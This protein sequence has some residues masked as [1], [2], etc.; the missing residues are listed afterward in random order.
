MNPVAETTPISI[1]LIVKN[2]ATALRACLVSLRSFIRPCDEI[3][4][5]DTGSDDETPGV[6]VDDKTLHCEKNVLIRTDLNRSDMLAL[7]EKYLPNFHH[8][9]SEDPQFRGGFLRSF[10]EARQIVTDAAKHDVIFWLDSDDI[11]LNG[12]ALRARTDL[13]F[14]EPA[15]KILFLPYQY[16]FDVDGSC[17]TL[18][19]RERLLRKSRYHW[20][21]A[22]HETIVPNIPTDLQ[23]HRLDE[24]DIT[25]KHA[26]A[27]HHIFSDIRN[28]AILRESYDKEKSDGWP[29][30]RT[31]FYLGNACRGMGMWSEAIKWYSHAILRSG[32]RDDRLSCGLNIAYGYLSFLRPWKALDW[33]L[34]C[35]KIWTDEPRAYYG[36]AKCYFDLHKW[37]ECLIWTQIG[38][39]MGVPMHMTAVDPLSFTFYPR[40]FE[41][42]SLKS[43][44]NLEAAIRV[45]SE[46][47]AA[48]PGLEAAKLLLQDLQQ[49]K[50]NQII[51]DSLLTALGCA[52]SADAG[53]EIIARLKPEVRQG[54]IELHVESHATKPEKSVTFFCGSTFEPW[55]GSSLLN[56]V[57]GSEKMVIQ[58]GERLARRGWTVDVYGKPKTEHRYKVM[59]GVAYRP[60]ESFDPKHPRDVLVLW[61]APAL[62]NTPFKAR[63][64]LVDM[65]DVTFSDAFTP[66][67]LS[68]VS[69]VIFKSKFHRELAP[70]IPD[71]KAAV[72][73]N[74]IDLEVLDRVLREPI[75]RNYH[76]VVW[77]SSG[78]RGLRGALVTW[79]HC[80][81]E[82]P[83]TDFNVFYGFTPLYPQKATETPYQIF[84][85]CACERHMFDYAEECCELQARLG[86]ITPGRVSTDDLY[87]HLRSA[88]VWLYPTKFPEISCISAMDAQ[89]CG[90][91]PLCSDTAALKETVTWGAF[92]EHNEAEKTAAAIRGLMLKGKDYDQYR[93]DMMADARKRFDLETLVDEWEKLIA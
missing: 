48:R 6:L 66:D 81:N 7:V 88:G 15:N 64:I 75:D 17:N 21:G 3:I 9:C 19:W 65:H 63:K 31:E 41:A 62:L 74:A 72:L 83:A 58:I 79:A 90:A 39:N 78:D 14:K 52:S 67:G 35:T 2:C 84:G 47:V 37:K 24:G 55:D 29:D 50:T 26:H 5:L 30:P 23:V 40:V 20:K 91:F 1:T 54:V 11:L 38:L 61:R 42:L 56:G 51:R 12:D 69:S 43:L 44:G 13:F 36:I 18:L 28:Y 27:R 93:L 92:I 80:K 70:N 33:F 87:R 89:A 68:R 10:A 45:G 85:D 57:G 34:Q 32:S 86:I 46:I 77:T 53:R 22:C 25:I 73:R 16:S 60:S 59:N 8:R 4:I 71:S 76:K 82:F 49:D